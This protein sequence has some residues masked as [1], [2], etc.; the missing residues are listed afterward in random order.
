LAINF[1]G[2]RAPSS[3]GEDHQA[4]PGEEYSTEKG[5][6]CGG[7]GNFPDN[8]H[9]PDLEDAKEEKGG[10]EEDEENFAAVEEED[11]CD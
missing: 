2:K 8:F 7:G 10:R 9:A 1:S 4:K 11:A 6:G 3:G 5:G